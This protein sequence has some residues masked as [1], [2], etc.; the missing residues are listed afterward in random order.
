ME[1]TYAF[2]PAKAYE[3]IKDHFTMWAGMTDTKNFVVGISGG[4]D[5]LVVAMLLVSLFGKDHVYGALLPNGKQADITDSYNICDILGIKFI[6][7]DIGYS[8]GHIISSIWE[9]R[10]HTGIYPSK[11]MEINL[12]ARIRMASLYAIAQC[13]NGR[14]INTSNLSEDMVG[15][16]FGNNAGSYTPLQELTATEV[17]SLGRWL[18]KKLDSENVLHNFK[19]ETLDPDNNE[20]SL[21][22][23]PGLPTILSLIEKTSADELQLQ[24]DEECLGFTYEDLDNFI[25]KN[26]GSE[27]FKTTILKRYVQNKFKLDI[28]H[29]PCPDFSYLPNNI[30]NPP[31]SSSDEVDN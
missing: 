17:R 14:V 12:P 26:V 3:N 28:I 25:R 16:N 18:A 10:K 5:S 21:K 29:M 6:N 22:D 19:G 20:Y 15:Y 30:I 8:V 23:L 13:V 31:I 1:T 24:S 2:D 27:E 9:T 4:K 7:M 11:D